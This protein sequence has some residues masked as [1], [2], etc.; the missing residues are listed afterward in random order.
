MRVDCTC[1][2]CL[3]CIV[4]SDCNFLHQNQGRVVKIHREK[5]VANQVRKFWLHTHMKISAEYIGDYVIGLLTVIRS[6]SCVMMTCY[7]NLG[8]SNGNMLCRLESMIFYI[9]LSFP[10]SCICKIHLE[11]STFIYCIFAV[12]IKGPKTQPKNRDPESCIRSN[13]WGLERCISY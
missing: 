6:S 1:V 3:D 10:V 7:R 4:H 8:S 5:R 11:V 13:I 9:N 12:L 2:E